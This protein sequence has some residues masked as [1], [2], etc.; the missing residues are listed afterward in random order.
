MHSLSCFV[1]GHA[2]DEMGLAAEPGEPSAA[3]ARQRELLESGAYPSL[4]T[5]AAKAA[6]AAP[7]DSFDLGLEAPLCGLGVERKL[8]LSPGR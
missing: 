2:L 7:G 3:A 4:A 1:V 6:D 8:P 5:A